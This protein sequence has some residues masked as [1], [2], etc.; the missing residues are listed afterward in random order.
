MRHRSLL[1]SAVL[2][3]HLSGAVAQPETKTITVM[4]VGQYSCGF[5]TAFRH[6]GNTQ[7]L[8][9]AQWILGFVTGAAAYGVS[10]LDPA[11]GV[12]REAILAWVD[13]WC[14]AHP[15]EVIV[16]AARAFTDAH[17]HR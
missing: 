17:P 12:D 9:N 4:G 13:N 8:T 2:T 11:Q 16:T 1:L 6:K 10:D 7:S 3:T 5:W 15:L 14:G